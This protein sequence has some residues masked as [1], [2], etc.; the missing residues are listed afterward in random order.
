MTG[1]RLWVGL[2]ELLACAAMIDDLRKPSK[3]PLL[4][5]I[6]ERGGRLGWRILGPS[7]IIGGSLVLSLGIYFGL[8]GSGWVE[9]LAGWT[10]QWTSYGLNLLGSSTTVQ[11]TVLSSDTF[12][13]DIVAECTAIGPVVLFMGAVAAYPSPLKTKGAGVL[14]GVTALSFVNLIRVMSLFWIGSN[15]PQYLGVAHLLI[16]QTAIIVLAITLWLFWVERMAGA[17]YR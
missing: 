3:G 5:G 1:V 6:P 7:A 11:G 15:F 9:V 2:K 12:A 8:L 10:A 17:R 13:V 14:L 4:Q 16:W